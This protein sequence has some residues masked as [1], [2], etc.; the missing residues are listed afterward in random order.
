VA[1]TVEVPARRRGRPPRLSR[2]A[3]LA[4]ALELVDEEGADALTM[5]RL[6]AELGVEAM[7]L[8]RHVANKRA[9][10][11][12]VA[13]QLMSEVDLRPTDRGDWAGTARH[14][15]VGIRAV[16]QA[17]PAAFELVGMRA[18]N[19]QAAVRPIERLLADLRAGGFP[20]ERAIAI[21]RLLASFVRGYAMGEIVGFTLIARA[22]DPSRLSPVDLPADEFPTIRSLGRGL[23][24]DPSEAQFRDNVETILD[25]LRLELEATRRRPLKA[26]R[27]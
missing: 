14:L 16:A 19:T 20:P 24:R 27:G 25:G 12:G 23:A 22:D 9:L 26:A 18:L 7:S 3:I 17:H 10:L 6:G 2:P 15:L 4:K 13:E 5:R 1:A 11:D 21:Y 8:Y